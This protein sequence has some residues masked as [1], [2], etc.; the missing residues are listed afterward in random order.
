MNGQNKRGGLVALAG[1]I[2]QT[3]LAGAVLI[4]WLLSGSTAAEA[5]FLLVLGGLGV[6][7]VTA[8]LFYCRHTAEVETLEMAELAASRGRSAL[9]D[10]AGGNLR[11]AQRRLHWMERYFAPLVTLVLAAY[12][13]YVAVAMFRRMVT[14]PVVPAPAEAYLGWAVAGGAFMAFLVSRYAIG[15]SK[16]PDWRLLRA[17]GGYMSVSVLGM[18]LL[19]VAMGALYWNVLWPLSVVGYAVAVAAGML[20]VELLLN[21]VLDFY[22]PRLHDVEQRPSFDSRLANLVSEPGSIAHSIA[23]ALNY[24]FGFEVSKTWFYQLLEK[25][26]IPLL[27]F[28]VLALLAVSSIVIVGPGQ[29]A[30][31]LTWGRKPATAAT[32]PSGISLKWPWPVQTADVVDVQRVRTLMAGVGG[33]RQETVVGGVPLYLWT[34]EHG[35]RTENNILVARERQSQAAS[36]GSD[37]LPPGE[38]LAA[39]GPA[40]RPATA[41]GSVG[42]DVVVSLMRIVLEIQYR[43]KDL[44]QF[45]Y[46]AADSEGMLETLANQEL[47]SY[48]AQREVDTLIAAQRGQIAGALGRVIQDRADKLNLGIQIVAVTLQGP[49][50]APRWPRRSR[51][52]STRNAKPRGPASPPRPRGPSGSRRPPGRCPRPWNWPPPSPC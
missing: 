17:G 44:Y 31:V 20:G 29:Q 40:S 16:A 13:L 21:F 30:V 25:T 7:L 38:A 3:L 32:R 35:E 46:G 23:E 6:W 52:S 2:L 48:A 5:V 45:A 10:E 4:V 51:T 33:Q 26:F 9:F 39:S 28:G 15:M 50:P 47:T 34:E 8:I 49:H 42:R 14:A 1:L 11:V 41:P 36:R 27:A 19:A 24:Q 18:A 43:V 12:N 22:R 37:S